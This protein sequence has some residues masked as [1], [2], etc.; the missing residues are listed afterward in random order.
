LAS[1]VR[2][3]LRALARKGHIDL[4]GPGHRQI[5][6]RTERPL[7]AR[8]PLVG[9]VEAGRPILADE[10]VEGQLPVPMEWASRGTNFA[11]R[12]QGDSMTGVGIQEGDYVVVRQQPDADHGDI[13]VATIQ[14]E[15]T[16]KR[17]WRSGRIVEL[18]PENPR[19]RPI[20][21]QSD[22]SMIQGVVVGLIRTY[23]W[24]EPRVLQPV[25]GSSIYRPRKRCRKRR[26]I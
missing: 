14:S 12:V 16:L 23:G 3:H 26:E 6:L 4:S 20:K 17:L 1:T 19:Y 24:R 13:V 18:R 25:N 8:V 7:T 21:L 11:L 10:N 9:H 2:D 5:K 15:T 22:S